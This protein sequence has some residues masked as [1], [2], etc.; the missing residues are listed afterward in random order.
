MVAS[1]PGSLQTEVARHLERTAFPTDRASLVTALE[2]ANA[3]GYLLDAGRRLPEDGRCQRPA[4]VSRALDDPAAGAPKR[5]VEPGALRR[6][7]RRQQ[8]WP[9]LTWSTE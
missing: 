4:D 5:T 1:A 8:G 2:E 7:R 3:P 9:R 6:G